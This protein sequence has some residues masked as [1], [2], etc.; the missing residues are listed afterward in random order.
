MKIDD[1]KLQG[2]VEPRL[3]AAQ[4]RVTAFVELAKKPAV[5]AFTAA[6]PQGKE[7]AK[8]AARAAKDDTAAAVSSVLGQLRTMRRPA[9]DRH[10]DGQRRPRR[11]R[12]RR[13]REAA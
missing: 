4:G 9:P 12:H 1:A 10:P 8:R 6:Q 5:D 11:R 7:S 3:A 2:K 13:R